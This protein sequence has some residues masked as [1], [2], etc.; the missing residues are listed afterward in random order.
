MD[1]NVRF[2]SLWQSLLFYCEKETKKLTVFLL[3]NIIVV[4]RGDTLFEVDFYKLPNG[5]AP[6]E[7]FLDS[8]NVKMRNKALL[9]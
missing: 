5:K 6:V 1:N 8:L 7:E 3:R 9:G 4:E 2:C